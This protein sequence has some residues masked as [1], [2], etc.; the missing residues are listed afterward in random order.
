MLYFTEALSLTIELLTDNSLLLDVEAGKPSLQYF[1]KRYLLKDAVKKVPSYIYAYMHCLCDYAFAFKF[2]I[3]YKQLCSVS[4]KRST[5]MIT[6][7]IM[8]SVWF[9]GVQHVSTQVCMFAYMRVS[10]F[11]CSQTIQQLLHIYMCVSNFVCSQTIQ[12][13][14]HI[15]CPIN[16]RMPQQQIGQIWHHIFGNLNVV[17]T[18]KSLCY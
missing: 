11:V 14:V 9:L 4:V 8:L 13:L 6:L 17:F 10:S 12:E 7:V 16:D 18:D 2:S 5:C 3:W 15:N 1:Q